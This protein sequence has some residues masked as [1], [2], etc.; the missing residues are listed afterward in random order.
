MISPVVNVFNVIC[1]RIYFFTSVYNVQSP[2]TYRLVPFFAACYI[3]YAVV[4]RYKIGKIAIVITT[5]A[6]AD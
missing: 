3:V 1:I 2:F 4:R 6:T 5:R